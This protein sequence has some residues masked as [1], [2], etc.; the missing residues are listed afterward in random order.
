M[1]VELAQSIQHLCAASHTTASVIDQLVRLVIGAQCPPEIG[2]EDGREQWRRIQQKIKQSLDGLMDSSDPKNKRPRDDDDQISDSKRQKTDVAT[3]ADDPVLFKFHSIS[4][5]SPIRKKV[6]INIHKSTVQFVNPTSQAVESVIPLSYLKRAFILPTRGKQKPHWTVVI[7]SSD[8]PDRGTKAIKNPSTSQ[9]EANSQVIF[10]MDATV[11]ATLTTTDY[12]S[13]EPA[14]TVQKKG[15]ES[16]PSIQNFLS[17]MSIPVFQPSTEVF[18]SNC[19]PNSG[20]PG[21]EA[22]LGAKTGTLWFFNE[23]ILWGEAKPCEFWAVE[24]LAKSGGDAVR[25]VSATGRMCSI[26]L[27]RKGDLQTGSEEGSEE[28]IGEETQF[29]MIDVREQDGIHRWVNQR[30]H[31]FGRDPRAGPPSSKKEIASGKRRS[32]IAGPITIHQLD[33]ASDD[34]DQDFKIDSD[35]EDL[36]E[37]SGGFDDASSESGEDESAEEDLDADAEGSEVDEEDVLDPR[38]HP[39]MREGAM[40]RM[41]RTA[42]DMV[43]GMV[44]DD[45]GVSASKAGVGSDQEDEEED[46][47]DD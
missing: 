3:S 9:I 6:D 24:D 26:F 21:L 33:D 5:T 37:Q 44:E 39:L 11:T 7:I 27:T 4:T 40:P 32:A 47:L 28:N 43:V 25:I 12:T 1:P 22:C 13:T 17:H 19:A 2:T 31:L 45:M 34:S 29:A 38:H 8:S 46:E 35:D 23:G 41:S 36:E 16:F 15:S 20:A 30:R 42:M 14:V 18:K 10:G